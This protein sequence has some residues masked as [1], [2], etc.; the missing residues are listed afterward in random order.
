V[1]SFNYFILALATNQN[2]PTTQVV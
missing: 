1:S 2:L